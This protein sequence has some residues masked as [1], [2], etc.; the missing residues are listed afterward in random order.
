[1]TKQRTIDEIL[2]NLPPNQ[3]E[4]VQNLR[5]LIKNNAPETVKLVK[6]RKITYKRATK[7]SFG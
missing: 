7:T 4:T 2:G 5:V 1:M 3:K 6:N